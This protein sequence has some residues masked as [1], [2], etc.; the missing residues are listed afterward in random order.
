MPSLLFLPLDAYHRGERHHEPEVRPRVQP[1]LAAYC[2]V[3]HDART[4]VP[5]EFEDDLVADPVDRGDGA[6]A[7]PSEGLSSFM[8]V[9]P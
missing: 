4:D 7:P 3:A 1:H 8:C 5:L 9:M 6:G 2:L